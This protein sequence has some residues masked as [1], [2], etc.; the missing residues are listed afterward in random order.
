MKSSRSSVTNEFKAAVAIG[1]GA[2][3]ISILVEVLAPDR[4]SFL[5]RYW[6]VGVAAGATLFFLAIALWIAAVI[7]LL[8]ARTQDILA[9]HGAYDLCRH[10]L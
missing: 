4:F 2:L 3:S 7:P 8:R 1:F 6:G 9:E 10:P 5:G